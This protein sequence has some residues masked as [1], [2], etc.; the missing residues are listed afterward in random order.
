MLLRNPLVRKSQNYGKVTATVSKSTCAKFI[1]NFTTTI[2]R[3]LRGGQR[4]FVT[5]SVSAN[6]NAVADGTYEVE[7]W[8][9][10][11]K[12]KTGSVTVS[13]GEGTVNFSFTVPKSK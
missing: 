9:E 7:A 10:R 8:H 3:I 1:P 5:Y 12:T 6:A 2:S 13:G 4:I 11:L